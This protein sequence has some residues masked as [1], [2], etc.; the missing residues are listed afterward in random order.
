MLNYS[1]DRRTFLKFSLAG[2]LTLFGVCP[3]V[4]KKSYADQ[5]PEGRLSLYNIHTG[6]RLSVTYRNRD[7]QYD[8]QALKDLN[9]LLRCVIDY[10]NMVDNQFG[11]NNELHIISGYRTPAFNHY[12]REEGRHVAHNSFHMRGRAIDFFIP[13]VE[14]RN[15]RTA[16]LSL[17]YGG[18]GY[19]PQNGFVHIDSGRFRTW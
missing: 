16:A 14:L 12:L 13:K 5:I 19:Y 3:L 17:R 15:L 11:G 9:W 2:A 7:G 10:L 4:A 6:E 1:G 8:P 18:V